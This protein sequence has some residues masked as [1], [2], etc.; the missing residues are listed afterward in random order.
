MTK[1]TNTSGFASQRL[2]AR[3]CR[4]GDA[5]PLANLMTESIS[6]CLAGW[7]FPLTTSK[8]T[9]I[10]R[11]SLVS[12]ERGISFPATLT[13]KTNDQPIGWLKLTASESDSMEYELSYWIGDASQRQGYAFEIA[14]EAIKFAFNDLAA[15]S[16][17]A[18]A[19]VEN[20]ASHALLA[21]LGMTPT[22]EKLVWAAARERHEAC[23]FWKLD[24][25]ELRSAWHS[26]TP[27][28]VY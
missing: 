15:D 28:N 23:Q 2:I 12:A 27:I 16:V 7:P 17:I 20:T 9:E 3:R 14:S 22:Y 4:L 18:G 8:A 25:A 21:K 1:I 10:I 6:R 11:Q 13:E 24:K 26:N 5:E 19:Q